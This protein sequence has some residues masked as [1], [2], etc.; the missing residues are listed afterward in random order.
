VKKLSTRC[1][2]G[3][4]LLLPVP[5]LA[6]GAGA[7]VSAT[8]VPDEQAYTLHQPV[9]ALLVLKNV[10]NQPARVDFGRNFQGNI[11]LV[12]NGVSTPPPGLPP[13]GGI[14]FPGEVELA[15]G[16]SYSRRLLL[17]DWYRF[18]KPGSYQ[19][20]AV[21]NSPPLH[22]KAASAVVIDPRNP[23]RLA[24]ACSE[25]SRQARAPQVETSVLA[26]RALS[27][28]GDEACL[29][30]LAEVVRESFHG[31]ESAIA[32]LLRIGTKPAL[33]ALAES[34]DGLRWEQQALALN[35]AERRG[36]KEELKKELLKAGRSDTVKPPGID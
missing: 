29:G 17:D 9:T 34:W 14:S 27:Y 19:V 10:S 22:L 23:E 4:A 7:G 11:H 12:V 25:L 18:E 28:V 33:R 31:K 2:L 1:V 35:E 3:L 26:A 6:H 15:P 36:K 32:G 5:V 13:E 20:S 8:L 21:V 16:A 24:K 30:S